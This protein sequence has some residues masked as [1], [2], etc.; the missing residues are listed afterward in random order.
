V[1]LFSTSIVNIHAYCMLHS[2]PFS[3][4]IKICHQ[5][6]NSNYKYFRMLFMRC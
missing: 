2:Q 1:S 6:V 4:I 5:S 3:F